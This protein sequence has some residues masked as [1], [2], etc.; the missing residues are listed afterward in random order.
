MPDVDRLPDA[1]ITD[2]RIHQFESVLAKP[3]DMERLAAALAR[4]RSS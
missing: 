3:Y 1:V 4:Q 2:H